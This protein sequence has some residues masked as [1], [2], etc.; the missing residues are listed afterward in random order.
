[1]TK[2]EWKAEVNLKV[3][4]SN[5]LVCVIKRNP[6]MKYLCGY[7][8][9]P[10]TF[11]PIRKL[12]KDLYSVPFSVHGGAT[13]FGSIGDDRLKFVGFDC[14]HAGDLI[15]SMERINEGETYRNMDYVTK[16]CEEL[17]KQI[18][19]SCKG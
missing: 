18:R 9:I 16:E 19:K 14:A 12:K 5:G 13:F 1:M 15:P 2:Q 17:A 3:F 7:V 6:S 11:N 10:E 4:K 8:E